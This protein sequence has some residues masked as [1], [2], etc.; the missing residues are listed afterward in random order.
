MVLSSE[1]TAHPSAFRFEIFSYP[2]GFACPAGWSTAT[3]GTYYYAGS[4]AAPA[5]T[6]P[7]SHADFGKFLIRLLINNGDAGVSGLPS[8]QFVDET[9]ALELVADSG[10]RDTAF[11]EGT[12]FDAQNAIAALKENLRLINAAL[13][14]GFGPGS[15]ADHAITYVKLQQL[16]TQTLIGNPTGVTANAQAVGVTGGLEFSGSNIQRGAL[17]GAVTAAAGSGVTSISANAVTTTTIADDNV[18][19]P[20]IQ[21]IGVGLLGN[22]AGAAS[23]SLITLGAGL[24]FVASTLVVSAVAISSLASIAAGTFLGNITGGAAAPVALTGAQVVANLPVATTLLKGLVPAP[25]TATGK[26]LK[27]DLTWGTPAG[28]FSAPANPADNAKLA[29][30]SAGAIVYASAIKTDGTYLARGGVDPTVLTIGANRYAHAMHITAGL[31]SGGTINHD[32]VQWGVGTNNKLQLGSSTVA[33]SELTGRQIKLTGVALTALTASTE[34]SDIVFDSAQTKQFATGA[35][36]TQR[37]ARF[38]APTYGFVG[39]SVLT[40][41]A[42]VAISAAPIAGTNATITQALALWVESGAIGFGS[43]A[44]L[45]GLQ[46][47]AHNSL[48]MVGRSSTS[49]DVNLVTWGVATDQLALGA[50]GVAS[51]LASATS[52]FTLRLGAGTE[53]AFSTTQ[54]DA[55][56]NNIV[57][58][59]ALNGVKVA[60]PTLGTA[61]TDASTTVSVAGGGVYELGVN[62]TANRSVGLAIT[63]SPR[64]KQGISIRKYTTAAFNLTVNDEVG[65]PLYTFPQAVKGIADFQ[66][67]A[68]TSKFVLVGNM[69]LA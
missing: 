26:Y 68:A 50:D 54:L 53:W 44:A 38:A 27:D 21:D 61:L 60:T 22:P 69:D 48:A 10:L 3:D 32:L 12:Q 58:L 25:T 56:S 64:D 36:T 63:G 65:N 19:L 62:L 35:L 47:F 41:A 52:T 40:T 17:T 6:L 49:T 8:T 5:F 18:T 7:A 33:I 13:G 31:D 9:T 30:A 11:L 15:I 39:A 4:S 29:Y 45:T 43:S 37:N 14:G 20:K 23:P 16:A 28:S 51:I 57:N 67:N 34:F 46:R 59:A 42:T 66:Y 1:D 2:P 24:A 55:N